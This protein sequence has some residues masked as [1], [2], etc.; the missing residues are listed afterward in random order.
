MT[1]ARDRKQ[2]TRRL[3]QLHGTS[4]SVAR[5][6]GSN[7][8]HGAA[9][10]PR[11]AA[12]PV[13]AFAEKGREYHQDTGDFIR[14]MA[15]AWAMDGLT[16]LLLQQR[17]PDL[18][19]VQFINSRRRKRQPQVDLREPEHTTWGK[20]RPEAVAGRLTELTVVTESDRDHAAVRG[21]IDHFRSQVD[22][23]ILLNPESIDLPPDYVP[24]YPCPPIDGLVALMYDAAVPAVENHVQFTAG[25]QHQ[26]QRPLTASQSATLLRDRHL[27]FLRADLPLL[28]IVAVH[29]TWHEPGS[30]TPKFEQAVH[31]RLAACG[32]PVLATVP[33]EHLM[34]LNHEERPITVLDSPDSDTATDLR[35]A[36][37]AIATTAGLTLA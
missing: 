28:G 21:V 26:I 15:A 17:R 34:V 35:H 13:L 8:N 1:V 11:S 20:L 5:R 10:A 22:C 2:G 7:G 25:R 36:A 30:A 18:R 29:S 37:R 19:L 3:A 12:A 16:V 6:L 27:A 23:I 32:L 4:Y 9:A 24:H 33:N 31:R 14:N